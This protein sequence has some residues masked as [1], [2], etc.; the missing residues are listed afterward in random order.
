MTEKYEMGI[1]ISTAA[2]RM[3]SFASSRMECFTADPKL[4][5]TTRLEISWFV[6]AINKD[7]ARFHH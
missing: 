3:H 6:Q 4:K 5:N 2:Y 7:A 1:K